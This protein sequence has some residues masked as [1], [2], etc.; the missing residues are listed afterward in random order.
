ME[1]ILTIT[2][3]DKVINTFNYEGLEASLQLS[4]VLIWRHNDKSSVK[5]WELV[6][7]DGLHELRA[8]VKIYLNNK[9]NCIYNY[10]FKGDEIENLPRYI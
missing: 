10:Q 9:L 2:R 3:D 7:R 1:T 8:T 4:K 6:N 5:V